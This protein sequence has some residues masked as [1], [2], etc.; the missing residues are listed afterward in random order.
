MKITKTTTEEHDIFFFPN[1]F[2]MTWGKFREVRKR[3]GQPVTKYSKC[4][5]CGHK[6][7][8]DEI[9]VVI[10]VFGIGNMFSCFAC[11]E[12]ESEVSEND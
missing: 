8:E 6:F 2:K 9:P 5:I 1:A 12:K 3:I 10:K 7:L 4:F 11:C